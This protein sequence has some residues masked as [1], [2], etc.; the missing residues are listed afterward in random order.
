MRGKGKY[1]KKFLLMLAAV[2]VLSSSMVAFAA[3]GAVKL[4]TLKIVGSNG[5]TC[6][7]TTLYTNGREAEEE[8]DENGKK[9][10]TT[11]ETPKSVTLTVNA[12]AA[13]GVSGEYIVTSSDR[14]IATVQK[15][16]NLFGEPGYDK[17]TITAG[18]KSG[19]AVI[20]VRDKNNYK[21]T[22]KVTVTVNTLAETINF[23]ANVDAYNTMTVAKG[24]K[25][26]LGAA[27]DDSVTGKKLKYSVVGVRN[28]D[29]ED[30]Q[31][32]AKNNVKVTVD[33]KGN[34]SGKFE[35]YALVRVQA[36]DE[37][38]T[39]VG[40]TKASA[41]GAYAD[42]EV[43]VKA[44]AA[45]DITCADKTKLDLKSNSASE[46]H[47]YDLSQRLSGADKD[48]A[49]YASSNTK[50]AKV[51]Q[52]GLITAVGN[53]TAKITVT[54]KDGSKLRKAISISV[55]VTTDIE[56]IDVSDE[57]T[58]LLG[59]SS[60]LGAKVDKAV[61]NKKLIYHSEDENIAKISTSGSISGKGEGETTVT[62]Q[63][64]EVPSVKKTVKVHVIDPVNKISVKA[65]T[66]DKNGTLVDKTSTTLY[67]NENVGAEDVEFSE[68]EVAASITTKL[69]KDPLKDADLEDIVSVTTSNAKVAYYEDGWIIANG[70]GSAK[71]TFTAKDGSKKKATVSV[72]VIQKVDSIS[73]DT[74]YVKNGGSVTLKAVTNDANNKKLD[75]SF[76]KE[77]GVTGTITCT[78]AGKLTAK[79]VTLTDDEP[80][81]IGTLTVT[82]KDG[83]TVPKQSAY[84]MED[85]SVY[86]VATDK[87]LSKEDL[88]E[89]DEMEGISIKKGEK[90]AVLQQM[91]TEA[92]ANPVGGY[93]NKRDLSWKASKAG[94]VSIDKNGVLTAKKPGVTTVTVKDKQSN[95]SATVEVRVG[96]SQADY[97]K[98]V[99]E[100]INLVVTSEDYSWIGLNPSFDSKAG[101]V[102]IGLTDVTKSKEDA[103]A[104]KAELKDMVVAMA[105]SMADTSYRS[106][107]LTGEGHTWALNRSGKNI[108]VSYD[109][110]QIGSYPVTSYK[111]AV[112]DVVDRMTEDFDQGTGTLL[113]CNGRDFTLT[114][115]KVDSA[116]GYEDL[117][118]EAEYSITV[119]AEDSAIDALLDLRAQN[120][121]AD[122]NQANDVTE[123]GISSFTYDPAAN[124]VTVWI[125]DSTKTLND[126]K[127][128]LTDQVVD[129][130]SAVFA[131]VQ[132]ATVE[133][134][135]KNSL[136]DK[137]HDFNRPA[138]DIHDA[139][140]TK[141]QG[142]IERYGNEK[143][144]TLLS[145]DVRVQAKITS[146]FNGVSF[147]NECYVMFAADKDMVDARVDEA[148]NKAVDTMNAKASGL[149][150]VSYNPDNNTVS[151]TILDSAKQI[152][153]LRGMGFMS[154][155]NTI[156]RESGALEATVNGEE[157]DIEDLD[158]EALL[159]LKIFDNVNKMADL[160]GKVLTVSVKLSDKESIDYTVVFNLS[161]SL[162]SLPI[163]DVTGGDVSV[164]DVTDGD[165]SVGDVTDG[166]VTDGDAADSDVTD[167]DV[168][169]GDVTDGD[170]AAADVTDGDV[171]DGDAV[172]P[173][174]AA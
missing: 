14:D 172:V 42:V 20:T 89:I 122:V 118:Y 123:T 9:V 155:L 132:T 7:K 127:G 97:L 93:A 135:S 108:V 94:I 106:A 168:T 69:G 11:L 62:V 143:L 159:D 119:R 112:R 16:D 152:E 144:S 130:C 171:T 43:E 128:T 169:D 29:D 145:Q 31:T 65:K 173:E 121:I 58:V 146:V 104:V 74:V 170:A 38:M 60:K 46:K 136:I 125:S 50:V 138:G 40:K 150:T 147:T 52:R 79:N 37:K 6:S 126:I 2:L 174:T 165:V 3:D 5:K 142:Y 27:V 82:A 161:A 87:G 134:H 47:T 105:Y 13:G 34:V 10:G 71:I 102:R 99:D 67:L 98:S 41:W 111:D 139:V 68:T 22:A 30:W 101:E 73:L 157:V 113:E 154:I 72:K 25:L 131:E 35:G 49:A 8:F 45:M 110:S 83:T 54:P 120:G 163:G 4:K 151:C 80:V 84:T 167:G 51:N 26:N 19:K 114:A 77:A 78:K 95:A 91:I 162:S 124:T 166:D 96:D 55:K 56:R 103:K 141:L 23:G 57:I 133:V 109:G 33:S 53:G 63:S 12:L 66:Y 148:I 17:I 92:Y 28:Q 39:P 160:N 100:K 24:G 81:L 70:K 156:V 48:M 153:D 86:A 115:T 18:N 44:S 117:E 36:Q 107:T 164:G 76:T 129:S 64:Q 90:S 32:P 88:Q 75:Y 59:K 137:Y 140:E 61:S 149:V 85:I 158:A 116:K 15:G 1:V 21:K